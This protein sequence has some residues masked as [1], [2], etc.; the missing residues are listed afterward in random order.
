[1]ALIEV[2]YPLLVLAKGKKLQAFIDLCIEYKRYDYLDLALRMGSV[3]DPYTV[4]K[5][6]LKVKQMNTIREE[7]WLL[8]DDFFKDMPEGISKVKSLQENLI[9]K[10]REGR[11]EGLEKGELNT[12][13][14]A[15]MRLLSKKFDYV[16]EA[17]MQQIEQTNDL[18]RLQDWFDQAIVVTDIKLITFY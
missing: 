17:I 10:W 9:D 16:P 6:L 2:N 7:T 8:I 4:W 1:M 12:T 11:N 14:S 3:N 5:E 13:R 15:L 18:A